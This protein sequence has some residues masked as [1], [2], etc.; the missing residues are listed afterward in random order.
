[1]Q[2]IVIHPYVK[3]VK[4]RSLYYLA[5]QYFGIC[6]NHIAYQGVFQ[7]AEIRFDCVGF[8]A[9]I[10][11]NVAVV[12]Y[13]ATCEGGG[14]KKALET[15]KPTCFIATF[16]LKNDQK[17]RTMAGT[18][19]PVS[20]IKQIL[21]LKKQGV[22]NREMARM[23]GVDK[24]TVNIYVRFIKDNHLIIDE[25]F[26]ND[27]SELEHLFHAGNPAY[28]DER[29]KVFLE[30]LPYYREQLQ[31]RHVTRYLLWT[32]YRTRHH[33][34]YG[35]SQFLEPMATCSI[36]ELVQ[37]EGTRIVKRKVESYNL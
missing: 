15:V 21:L 28:T 35:K 18:I 37:K 24:E 10:V 12:Y 17:Q 23:E 19:T 16:A 20:K 33:D 26:N 8:D 27:E 13:L 5:F 4:F 29:M 1:M 31:Q 6:R 3:K 11:G 9:T 30:E 22:S 34:G 2:Q 14:F 7:N 36:L 32:G 25:L